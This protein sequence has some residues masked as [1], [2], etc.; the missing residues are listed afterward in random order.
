[1]HPGPDHAP[2]GRAGRAAPVDTSREVE[3]E[4]RRLRLTNLDRVLWP[5][6]GYTKGDL[7]EYYLA[8]APALLPHLAGRPLTLGRWPQGIERH[9]FAQTE[10]RGRPDWLPVLPLR[11]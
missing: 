8:V 10:C 5:E 9:G 1:M 4:G 3:V 11:L 6:A 2:D 7:I